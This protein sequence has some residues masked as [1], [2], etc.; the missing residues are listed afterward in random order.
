MK[1]VASTGVRGRSEGE[2]RAFEGRVAGAAGVCNA[3]DGALVAVTVEA[4]RED[5]WSGWGVHSPVQWLM[6]KAG[7]ARVTARRVVLVA[8]RAEELPVTTQLLVEGRLSLDQ[9]A[10]VAR[11]TPAAYEASVC[12]LAVQATVH[13]IR[14]ATRPYDF[15]VEAPAEPRE[16]RREVSFGSDDDG[17]WWARVRLGAEEG[18]VVEDALRASRD[19]LHDAARQAAKDAAA[20]EGRSTTTGTDAELGVP[21][22]GWADAL[23]G[24]ATS[25]L[26]HDA[27]GAERPARA[28]VH[29]HLERPIDGDQWRAEVHGGPALPPWLRRYLTCDCAIEVVWTEAGVPVSTCRAQRT[30][31]RKVRRLIEH[32]DRYRC[33]VPG[34]G[35]TL[36]LQ[37]HH[38]VHWEDDGETVT[39]NLCCL[40]STHHRMHHQGLLGIT[41]NADDPKGLVFTNQHGL[42]IAPGKARP[43]GHDDMPIVAP[44]QAP[45]G[46]RL[47]KKWVTFDTT[48]TGPPPHTVEHRRPAA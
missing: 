25:A 1:T 23:V 8:S 45:T 20:A 31:P 44:Y 43:P 3:A 6:L 29:L 48:T 30:P 35:S 9:A 10:T 7:L 40:C 11:Y 17:Q 15:D 32:R 12:D 5:W 4:L 33:R 22:I 26:G 38:I 41:G 27:S 21:R 14:E 42:V 46:E 19:R 2:V 28:T 37:V 36:W 39:W 47:H 13:Q 18:K 34:C 24:V 16:T